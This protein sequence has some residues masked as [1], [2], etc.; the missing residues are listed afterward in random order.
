MEGWMETLSEAVARL[1]AA[2][3]RESFLATREGL[4]VTRTGRSYP[5]EAVVVDE[6]S[7]FEGPSD[8][9]DESTL[10]AIRTEDGVKG[11]WVIAYGAGMEPLDAELAPRL[12]RGH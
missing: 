1:E 9:A 7:R 4:R 6:V 12:R 5:P 2:G 3:Y 8:P 10:F 11:T